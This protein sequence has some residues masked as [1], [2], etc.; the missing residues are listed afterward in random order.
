MTKREDRTLTIGDVTSLYEILGD[1][2]V[3]GFFDI[4][5]PKEIDLLDRKWNKRQTQK[6]ISKIYGVS[7]TRIGQLNL[8]TIAKLKRRIR[9]ASKEHW[10]LNNLRKKNKE[11]MQENDAV[12]DANKRL[13]DRFD[14]LS[15]VD[16]EEIKRVDSR[17]LNVE[18]VDFTVRT[19][20]CLYYANIKTLGDLMDFS[21]VK[22]R[23]FRNMGAKST[24]EIK[25]VMEK[26]G[27]ELETYPVKDF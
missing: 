10:E 24:A 25:L 7:E 21:I 27:L 6:E 4:I 13:S 2:E 26:Y 19:Y 15:E 22:L 9:E 17:L 14:R 12:T 5:E 20:N 11:L 18:D 8:R 16:K 3:L 1:P 23:R